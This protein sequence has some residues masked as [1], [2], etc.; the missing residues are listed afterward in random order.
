MFA[1]L[2]LMLSLSDAPLSAIAAGSGAWPGEPLTRFVTTLS[3]DHDEMLGAGLRLGAYLVREPYQDFDLRLLDLVDEHADDLR[4]FLTFAL[5]AAA[6]GPGLSESQL[7]RFAEAGGQVTGSLGDMLALLHRSAALEKAGA[8][9]LR[10]DVPMPPSDEV[11][12]A[13]VESFTDATLPREIAVPCRASLG[14]VGRVLGI[15]AAIAERRRFTP[16]YARAFVVGWHR[17]L[18]EITPMLAYML[19]A[20][21]APPVPEIGPPADLDRAFAQMQANRENLE[22]ARRLLARDPKAWNRVVRPL[23]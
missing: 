17:N 23:D 14:H 5:H 6:L 2:A 13:F 10:H 11:A 3:A 15:S 22:I 8:S 4:D 19:D 12:R 7:H 18:D 21:G 20:T 1:P 9:A 16:D